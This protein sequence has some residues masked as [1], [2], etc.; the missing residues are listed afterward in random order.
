M[1]M[2]IL[3]YITV[4]LFFAGFFYSCGQ[5]DDIDLSKI[6]FSNIENLYTQPLPVIQRCV[7]GK[8]KVYAQ[9]GGD[10]GIS[11]PKD[12]YV[13]IYNDHYMVDYDDDN[14]R[15]VYFT[16]KKHSF[17]DKGIEYKTWVM[18]DNELDEGIYYF[19]SV[20]NDTLSVGWVPAP[21]VTFNQFSSTFT[22]VK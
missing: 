5:N 3:K 8:W 17:V 13:D 11:Y 7:E 6:D 22:R 14:Q 19:V 9:Y 12:T 4:V 16:W 15:I 20:R 18:W 1:K 10:A 21:S 2:S